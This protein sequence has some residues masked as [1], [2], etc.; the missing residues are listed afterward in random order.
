MRSLLK[1]LGYITIIHVLFLFGCQEKETRTKIDLDDIRPKAQNKIKE[2]APINHSDTLNYLYKF[3]ANDSSNLK[4]TKIE[5]DTLTKN[6]FL[7]RFSLKN[8]RY[9]LKDT[10]QNEFHYQRWDF[11]DSASCYEAFYNWLDQAGKNRSSIA[12]NTGDVSHESHGLF[13]ISNKQIIYIMAPQAIENLK[14]I[15]WYCGNQNISRL[16]YILAMKP[17][18]K[19]NWLNYNNGK[20]KS[21]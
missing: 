6:Q 13:L 5:A 18:Q 11:K 9:F 7:D 14:W 17:R 21:L 12:L 8:N 4:I 2:I 1:V 10:N 19:T 20:I 3:Y 16:D 15:K